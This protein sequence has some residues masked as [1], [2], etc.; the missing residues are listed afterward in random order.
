MA[1]GAKKVWP[2]PYKMAQEQSQADLSND[3]APELRP[4]QLF[5]WKYTISLL[6]RPET[7]DTST[8]ATSVSRWPWDGIPRKEEE[9][10]S[11]CGRSHAGDPRA[12]PGL[13]GIAGLQVGG[14]DSI[15]LLQLCNAVPVIQLLRLILASA[16]VEAVPSWGG[17]EVATS[18][19]GRPGGMRVEAAGHPLPWYLAT[20]CCHHSCPPTPWP[21][22]LVVQSPALLRAAETRAGL[23]DHFYHGG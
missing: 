18:E 17:Q 22:S 19:A 6:R 23:T 9:E 12:H 8:W 5:H 3:F 1:R 21:L 14:A 2:T 11:Q 20:F 16:H 4:R 10:V 15:A 7:Q 13:Q